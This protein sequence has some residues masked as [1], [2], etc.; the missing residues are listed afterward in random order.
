MWESGP[1]L[2]VVAMAALRRR[3]FL[4]MAQTHSSMTVACRARSATPK[5]VRAGLLF[6]LGWH[7]KS[8]GSVAAGE[9]AGRRRPAAGGAPVAQEQAL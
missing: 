4:L 3:L 1:D 9:A 5:Q 6:S 2:V 7:S 8:V